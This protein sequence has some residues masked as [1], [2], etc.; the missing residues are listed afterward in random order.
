MCSQ[1]ELS[2]K[3]I[4]LLIKWIDNLRFSWSVGQKDHV[5]VLKV[6]P[7]QFLW[8]TER[9]HGRAH[10]RH[11]A[12]YIYMCCGRR[13]R[14]EAIIT[15][16]SQ[17]RL[18]YDLKNLHTIM[19]NVGQGSRPRGNIAFRYYLHILAT[20]THLEIYPSRLNFFYSFDKQR[21]PYM[22]NRECVNDIKLDVEI[23]NHKLRIVTQVN[24]YLPARLPENFYLDYI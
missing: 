1:F 7:A 20:V 6:V 18:T 8:F 23:E 5:L 21:R 10:R 3:Y 2:Q 15:L 17:P 22:S 9:G 13:K 4:K 11:E 19:S 12:R 24:W 14:V 16:K